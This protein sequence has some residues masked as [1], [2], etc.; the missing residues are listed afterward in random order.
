MEILTP[1]FGLIFWSVLIF[2]TVFFLLAKSVFWPQV[3][4]NFS[5][6]PVP[7]VVLIATPEAVVS[8]QKMVL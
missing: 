6:L 4:S 2:G 7:D 1:S 5:R 8:D 3:T